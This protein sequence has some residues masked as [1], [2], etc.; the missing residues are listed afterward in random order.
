M[1]ME[2]RPTQIAVIEDCLPRQRANAA[3]SN[4]Q[5]LNAILLVAENG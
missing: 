1:R 5:A 3:L 4:L 2:L